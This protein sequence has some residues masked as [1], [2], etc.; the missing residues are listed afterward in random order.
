MDSEDAI[1][2]D[3]L[4]GPLTLDQAIHRLVGLG[5]LREDADDLV[6]EWADIGEAEATSQFR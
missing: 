1:M 5:Y 3:F 2:R 4:M 6:N